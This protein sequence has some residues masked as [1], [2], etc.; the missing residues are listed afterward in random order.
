M[1]LL[2]DLVSV[3]L[4]EPCFTFTARDEDQEQRRRRLLRSPACNVPSPLCTCYPVHV[5]LPREI[6]KK[7]INENVRMD[8][9]A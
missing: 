9:G 4:M 3:I 7:K 5:Y 2:T 8:C 6:K 1:F